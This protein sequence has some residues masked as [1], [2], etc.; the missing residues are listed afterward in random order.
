[1]K[2]MMKRLSNWSGIFSRHGLINGLKILRNSILVKVSVSTE[3]LFSMGAM[4]PT[5]LS[6]GIASVCN[7]RCLACFHGNKDQGAMFVKPRPAFMTLEQFKSIADDALIYAH[8]LNLTGQG[9]SFLNPDI[10]DIIA[11][12]KSKRTY[13]YLDTNGHNVDADRTLDSGLDKITYALDGFSQETYEKYRIGGN[14]QQ[15]LNSIIILSAK[16]EARRS[17]IL[18]KVK[19]LVHA[20]NEHEV[21]AVR[22][23]FTGMSNV[24]LMLDYFWIPPEDGEYVLTDR[25]TVSK[26]M[27]NVWSPKHSPEFNI[28][29]YDKERDVFRHISS[30][31][32]FNKMC[33]LV[34]IGMYINPNG[35]AYPCCKAALPEPEDMY[36]GNVFSES[37]TEVFNSE[38][39]KLFRN[40]FRATGGHTS[41]CADCW[42]NKASLQTDIRSAVPSD[43]ADEES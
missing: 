3:A 22:H 42:V 38:K 11:Y 15:V 25:Y 16:A 14:F 21:P 18:I 6:V 24:E 2:R 28:Y 30:D 37:V 41:L 20:F 27:Y 9:E 34:Y 13:V 39:A 10:Y 1:M 40:R 36:L 7:L 29:T 35:D 43:K 32:P 4:R 12:A 8:D 26:N 5:N 23:F 33:E 31:L 19:F 17:S